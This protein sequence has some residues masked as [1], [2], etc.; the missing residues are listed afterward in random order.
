M[1]IQL[2][3]SNTTGSAQAYKSNRTERNTPVQTIDARFHNTVVAEMTADQRLAHLALEVRDLHVANSAYEKCFDFTVLVNKHQIR[4]G[5][6]MI[7]AV[8]NEL[9]FTT[10]PEAIT[11]IMHFFR[12]TPEAE[13]LRVLKA[14]SAV[15]QRDEQRKYAQED[16]AKTA[17]I[18]NFA[19][20]VQKICK[21]KQLDFKS[22]MRALKEARENP[23]WVFNLIQNKSLLGESFVSITCNYLL[24]ARDYESEED[25]RKAASQIATRT[26][27]ALKD[28]GVIRAHS[29][30][31][32]REIISTSTSIQLFSELF[33]A[34]G[35]D[36][37][38]N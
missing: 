4:L 23:R 30:D 32:K 6:L 29:V 22:T 24:N 8:D 28:L 18:K 31:P 26:R 5:D 10:S 7:F 1:N 16:E 20:A 36:I 25:M 35:I 14:Y 33:R 11:A 34:A 13:M 2:K 15:M 37:E 27:K 38:T 12:H 21:E 19:H 9:D 17:R 3:G